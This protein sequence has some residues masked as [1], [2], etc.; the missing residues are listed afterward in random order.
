[1][2]HDPCHCNWLWHHTFTSN[3]C[4]LHLPC[5]CVY[6]SRSD[7]WIIFTALQWF[8]IARRIDYW[9]ILNW[10]LMFCIFY[11]ALIHTY[12]LFFSTFWFTI[13]F[14]T[15][16]DGHTFLCALFYRKRVD[17]NPFYWLL[18]ALIIFDSLLSIEYT[19]KLLIYFV[20]I[21]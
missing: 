4:S 9:I 16:N 11:F 5:R 19:P 21:L 12:I 10:K 1:M 8:K 20:L 6:M 14:K 15:R 3:I 18:S 13:V 2:V 7:C 17:F